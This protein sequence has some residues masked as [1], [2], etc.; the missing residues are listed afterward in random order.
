MCSRVG[1]IDCRSRRA[2]L[3]PP[4]GSKGS[5][6]HLGFGERVARHRKNGAGRR[7]EPN[8]KARGE[9]EKRAVEAQERRQSRAGVAGGFALVA[10][11]A[12][13]TR[14]ALVDGR[15]LGSKKPSSLTRRRETRSWRGRKPKGRSFA[16]EGARGVVRRRRIRSPER[17]DGEWHA[18]RRATKER[19]REPENRPEQ[20]AV[21][22]KTSHGRQR[23]R[24]PIC[25]RAGE[26]KGGNH[27]SSRRAVKRGATRELADGLR[28]ERRVCAGG[29]AEK[30]ARSARES[31]D[32]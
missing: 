5:K 23:A 21:S 26:S 17:T 16:R 22:R 4:P 7:P 14:D 31:A 27:R 19:R 32:P 24:L 25:R 6:G 18:D 9:G 29:G 10:A 8:A 30:H 11:Q 15:H 13:R 1:N 28:S 20:D 3:H 12:A 2:T